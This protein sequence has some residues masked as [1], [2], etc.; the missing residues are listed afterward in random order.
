M[1]LLTAED[2][3]IMLF[4]FIKTRRDLIEPQLAKHFM[5]IFVFRNL[6]LDV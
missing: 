6:L 3:N 5:V 2:Y 4:R 1:H